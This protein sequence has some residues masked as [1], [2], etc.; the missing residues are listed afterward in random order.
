MIWVWIG[1]VAVVL[2]IIRDAAN[3]DRDVQRLLERVER[4]YLFHPSSSN[5]SSYWTKLAAVSTRAGHT[6]SYYQGYTEARARIYE[7]NDL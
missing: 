2:W 7:I 4:Q 5:T 3:L 1:L 6:S